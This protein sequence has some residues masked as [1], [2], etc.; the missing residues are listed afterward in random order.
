VTKPKEAAY[1]EHISPLISK[2]IALCKEHHIN[3]AMT[4][5]LDPAEECDKDADGNEQI[6][7]LFCTTVLPV[8]K[9][10]ADGMR[11]IEECRRVMYPRPDFA[12]FTIWSS[13]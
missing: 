10:D 6:G 13:K 9:S 5:A 8:D 1:D 11:R 7:P 3:A 2:V 12:A 4:F